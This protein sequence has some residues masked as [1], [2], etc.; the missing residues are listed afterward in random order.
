[1][2]LVRAI[3]SALGMLG[4]LD[5][6]PVNGLGTLKGNALS[7]RATTG[8][9]VQ[10]P[11]EIWDQHKGD[12]GYSLLLSDDGPKWIEA[13]LGRHSKRQSD[14]GCPRFPAT[15][16][17]FGLSN[18]SCPR[19]LSAQ[20]QSQCNRASGSNVVEYAIVPGSNNGNTFIQVNLY[21]DSNCSN[22]IGSLSGD[23]DECLSTFVEGKLSNSTRGFYPGCFGGPAH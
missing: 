22:F 7:Y 9:V 10:V 8:L 23:N 11:G 21:S 15:L 3:T 4:I 20:Q 12:E 14:G 18:N 13:S 5:E 2:K 16:M 19:E 6:P 1:M 17:A